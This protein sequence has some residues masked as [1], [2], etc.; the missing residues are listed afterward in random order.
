M[1]PTFG[2][3]CRT[4][5]AAIGATGDRAAPETFSYRMVCV[6][7]VNNSHQPTLMHFQALRLAQLYKGYDPA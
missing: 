1:Y 4:L 7:T 5:E 3:Y 2:D 6:C